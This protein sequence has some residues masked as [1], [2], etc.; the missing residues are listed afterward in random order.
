MGVR[1][2]MILEGRVDGCNGCDV[3]NVGEVVS[4]LFSLSRFGIVA[5]A[6][7]HKSAPFTITILRRGVHEAGAEEGGGGGGDKHSTTTAQPQRSERALREGGV[8][9][10]D[11]LRVRR[12]D[13]TAWEKRPLVFF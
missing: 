7:T 6:H 8:S 4:S 13:S 3:V 1:G 9:C 11:A 10:S 12:A 5:I 2:G